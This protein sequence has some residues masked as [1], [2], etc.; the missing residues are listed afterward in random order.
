MWQEVPVHRQLH[1]PGASAGSPKVHGGRKV[2]D[3]TRQPGPCVSVVK[4]QLVMACG[5][6]TF[7]WIPGD[8]DG[9]E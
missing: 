1:Q 3:E 2:G 5:H 4:G 8:S 9:Q 6:R 7:C